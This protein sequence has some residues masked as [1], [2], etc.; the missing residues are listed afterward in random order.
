MNV[1]KKNVVGGVKGVTVCLGVRRTEGGYMRVKNSTDESKPKGWF[2]QYPDLYRYL[3]GVGKRH[4]PDVALTK[5]YLV[6]RTAR[7]DADGVWISL[8][9]WSTL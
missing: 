6:L 1:V 2:I 4:G 5:L 9:Q 3:I 7:I 8:S